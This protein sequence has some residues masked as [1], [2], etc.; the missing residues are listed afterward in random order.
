MKT[1]LE[2]AKHFVDLY[3]DEIKSG[4]EITSDTVNE[5]WLQTKDQY[6]DDISEE[7]VEH[8]IRQLL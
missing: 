4:E 2:A 8:A 3:A 7:E 1:V 6:P 5:W